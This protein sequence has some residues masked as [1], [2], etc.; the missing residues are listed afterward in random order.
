MITRKKKIFLI[1]ALLYILYTIFPLLSDMIN[2]PTWL[3]SLASVAVMLYLYPKAFS[4]KTFYWFLAYAFVLLLY[5]LVGHPLAVGIG[6]IAD[7]KKIVIEYAF[8]LPAVSMFCILYYLKDSVLLRKLF[9]WSI[10]LLFVSFFV[11]IP[12]L[13]RYG[14][15]RAAMGEEAEQI[16]ILGLPSYALM[17]AYTLFL[18]VMC[19]GTKVFKDRYRIACL[20][21]V[22]VLFVVVY[23]TFVTTSLLIMIAI[24]SF[25]IIYNEKN[26]VRSFFIFAILLLLFLVFSNDSFLIG[27][28]DGIMPFFEGSAVEFKLNDFR[29]SLMQ[30]QITGD[31]IT[32]R[33]DYH[34]ISRQS[35]FINPIF[36]YPR[37]GGHSSL[38]DRLGGMGIVGTLPFVMI[39]VS[40]IQQMR[41]LFSTR[42]AK[43][44]FWTGIIAGF[45]YLYEKG[46]WGSE[47]WLVYM[48]L[49][50][51][52]IL[53]F[54]QK[55][56]EQNN[57]RG[58]Q[59]QM[60]SNNNETA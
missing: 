22:V 1:A 59:K 21:G 38:L 33:M 10:G 5:L 34:E 53:V 31:S 8:I 60:K 16:K 20:V 39:M 30:G 48:V 41:K 29:D 15:I 35:F 45:V 40:Y 27:M 55:T 43:F 57:S 24:V 47:G 44:F 49:M 54:E 58:L 37:V 6:V 12:L 46:L 13:Q 42:A 19:Y 14:S 52:G 50:P 3:P 56:I 23:Y 11:E 28:I 51:M 9:L 7:S 2:I 17:H 36:G 26:E 18:P 4:N 32:G 25:T